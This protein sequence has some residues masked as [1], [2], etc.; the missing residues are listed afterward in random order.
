MA[1]RAL[2]RRLFSI[3]ENLLINALKLDPNAFYEWDYTVDC[4][5]T[6]A[7]NAPSVVGELLV[8]LNSDPTITQ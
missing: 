5:P 6:L 1:A 3:E 4:I 7:K 2:K 8:A